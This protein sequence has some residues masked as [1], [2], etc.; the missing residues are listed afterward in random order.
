MEL[1]LVRSSASRE[2]SVKKALLLSFRGSHRASGFLQ[3]VSVGAT[4]E[5]QFRNRCDRNYFWMFL[6]I[7]KS[8]HRIRS[9]VWPMRCRSFLSP[10]SNHYPD[11]AERVFLPRIVRSLM[12]ST[13]G[14]DVRELCEHFEPLRARSDRSE[15]ASYTDRSCRAKRGSPPPRRESLKLV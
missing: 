7:G 11:R 15:N 8:R 1:S 9:S 4:L 10:C 6:P 2:S 13:V 3:L 12:V 5:L 14:D